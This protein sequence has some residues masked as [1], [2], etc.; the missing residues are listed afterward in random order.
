MASKKFPFIELFTKTYT[1][2]GRLFA[3]GH[4]RILEG[5]APAQGRAL[6]ELGRGVAVRGVVAFLALFLEEL[7]GLEGR[8]P[9]GHTQDRRAAAGA[10][11]AGLA[12]H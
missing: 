3:Q 9:G 5:G 1:P 11:G 4:H 12:T 6:F 7:P 2:M 8:G 10:D